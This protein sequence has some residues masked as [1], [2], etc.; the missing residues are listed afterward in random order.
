M[1]QPGATYPGVAM[2]TLVTALSP[3]RLPGLV[4]HAFLFEVRLYRSLFRW[5]T[6]RPDLGAEGDE[7][8]TYARTVTPVMWLWIF[9]SALELPLVHV[10]V[11]WEGVRVA[12]LVVGVWGLAWMVGLLASLYVYPHLL[13]PTALRVRHGASTEVA[14]PWSAVSRVTT[15]RRELPSTVWALQPEETEEGTLLRVGVSGVVNVHAQLR[16]PT[17]LTTPKG[18]M[19]VVEVSLFADEPRALLEQARRFVATG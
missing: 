19:E 7:P 10:L 11:P 18:P 6:R 1:S 2:H 3:R 17:T 4:K 5:V 8:F 14:V 15:E 12:L 9:A 13:S 16:E